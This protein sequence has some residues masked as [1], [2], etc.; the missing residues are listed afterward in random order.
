[1]IRV[2]NG[3]ALHEAI[4]KET[5]IRAFYKVENYFEK[6]GFE[7][8]SVKSYTSLNNKK[9]GDFCFVLKNADNTITKVNVDF[10]R[11][12]RDRPFIP[13]E[14]VQ[15][16]KTYGMDSWLYNSDIH[17]CAYSFKNG[18]VYLFQHSDLLSIAAYFNTETMWNRCIVYS[19][20]P[21]KYKEEREWVNEQL[22]KVEGKPLVPED[23]DAH[24]NGAFNYGWSG[25][26]RH[27]G[28][29]FNLT[30]ESAKSFR[31]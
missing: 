8:V 1:M 17:V 4:L 11:Q 30:L 9:Y 7:V 15:I 20:E 21:E 10:K 14:L 27:S 28:F 2:S 13:I 18:E 31:I 29:C 19:R 24:I 25:E 23:A 5:T 3:S 22:N 26:K 6:Q 16:S 12:D